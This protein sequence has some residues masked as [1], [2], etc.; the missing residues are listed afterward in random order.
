[1]QV[2]DDDLDLVDTERLVEAMFRRGD[3]TLIVQSRL[4]DR[5]NDETELWPSGPQ[6]ALIGLARYAQMEIEL[7]LLADDPFAGE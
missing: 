4:K 6:I 7:H 1:M 5:D 2:S 3:A